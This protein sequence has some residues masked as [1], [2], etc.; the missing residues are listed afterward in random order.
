MFAGVPCHDGATRPTV[1]CVRAMPVLLTALLPTCFASFSPA[2][3]MLPVRIVVCQSHVAAAQSDEV[4]AEE[5]EAYRMTKA[6]AE[7]PMNAYKQQPVAADGYDL[8]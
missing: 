1:A 4:T 7:D 5:M 6:R 8:V 2:G 3:F